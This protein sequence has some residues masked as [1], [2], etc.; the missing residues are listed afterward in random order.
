MCGLRGA[1]RAAPL[2]LKQ[3]RPRSERVTLPA[4]WK[5]GVL[6]NAVISTSV[7]SVWVFGRVPEADP[8]LNPEIY[9]SVVRRLWLL[10]HKI[11]GKSWPTFRVGSVFLRAGGPRGAFSF[12]NKIR[13]SPESL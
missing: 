1:L 11:H 7:E 8:R 9:R 10:R 3:A 13:Q 4:N 2:Q 12:T 6:A 5:R